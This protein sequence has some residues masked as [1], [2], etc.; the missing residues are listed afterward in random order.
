M[1]R[2]GGQ[3]GRYWNLL[4]GNA[5]VRKDEDIEAFT[6]SF[7]RCC[8]QRRQR[9]FHTRSALPGGIADIKGARAECAVGCFLYAAYPLQILVGEDWLADFQAHVFTAGMQAEQVRAWTDQRYQR[10]HQFLADR[11]DRRV[12]DLGKVLLEIVGQGLGLVRQHRHR[13]VSTHGADG[14]LPGDRHWCHQQLEVFLGIAERLLAVQQGI[15]ITG[16]AIDIGGQVFQVDLGLLQPVL[17][18]VADRQAFLEFGI[19]DDAPLLHIDQEHL[20]WLQAPFLDDLAVR[21]GQYAHFRSHH[22]Q[23]IVGDQIARRAQAVAVQGGTDLAAIGKG[24]R[25][26]AI[27]GLHQRR[28]VFVKSLAVFVH[29]R[30]ARPGF[31]DQH[32]HGVCHGIATGHQ[33]FQCI[34]KARRVA[35]SFRDQRPDF[36]QVSTEKFG[37]HGMTASAHPVDITA[38]GIDFTVV[39]DHAERV[40]Q[41]PGREGVG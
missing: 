36:F 40:R 11:V 9:G 26:R 28:V 38:Q 20:A 8:A 15:R 41:I 35:L 14:F 37:S 32:H 1:Y 6:D 17:V 7:F 3:Q 12:G 18:G 25:R 19:V 29:Q 22:H 23:V 24:Y 34:V 16:V 10:H 39:C 2:R 21:D 31:R 30:V 4:S 33:Q 27:P 13:V 5:A